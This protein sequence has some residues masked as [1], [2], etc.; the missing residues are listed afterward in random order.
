MSLAKLY[1]KIIPYI[2]RIDTQQESG[3]GF[4]IGYNPSKQL[5]AIATAAHVVVDAHEWGQPMRITHHSSEKAILLQEGDRAVF[6]D[7][8]RDAATI[9]LAKEKLPFPDEPLRMIDS[10]S[11]RAVGNR[12]AWMGFPSVAQPHL[13]LFEGI[14]SSFLDDEDCY[15]IDGVAINGV[16]GGPVFFEMKDDIPEIVGVISAY[17]PNHAG[18]TP[19]LLRAQDITPFEGTLNRLRNLHE[20]KQAERDTRAE[21]FSGKDSE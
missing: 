15:L 4:L 11:Y 1:E 6:I 17:I 21:P 13:C 9:M 16:S 19:G 8:E 3:T 18:N 14:I 7:K 20:A 2:V 10:S 12:L 5:A